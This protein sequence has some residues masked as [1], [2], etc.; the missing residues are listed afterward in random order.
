MNKFREGDIVTVKRDSGAWGSLGRDERAQFIVC[1]INNSNVVVKGFGETLDRFRG[2]PR[3][4]YCRSIRCSEINT[5]C[6]WSWGGHNEYFLL[7]KE[8]DT[9]RSCTSVCKS[10]SK[11]PFFISR[12]EGG[13]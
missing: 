13:K 3:N 7:D 2:G 11:C 9:C 6:S 8:D 5:T 4:S 12:F 1:K 10:D